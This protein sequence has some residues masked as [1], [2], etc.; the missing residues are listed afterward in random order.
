MERNYMER[1]FFNH[2]SYLKLVEAI[3]EATKSADTDCAA[4][5]QEDLEFLRQNINHCFDYVHTVDIA[6]TRIKTAYFRYE[7]SELRDIIQ[8]LDWNRH[9]THEAAIASV[10]ILNRLASIYKCDKLFLGDIA[11]R[12]QVADFCLDVVV[13]IF[14]NRSL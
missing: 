11:D 7:G 12:L 3:G 1:N 13:Q 8:T 4:E 5:A 6:E 2:E 9:N 10:S 14:Q